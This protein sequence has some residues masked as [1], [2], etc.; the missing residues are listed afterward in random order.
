MGA[1]SYN[2]LKIEDPNISIVWPLLN[3]FLL[4]LL[5]LFD[6]WL[7][8]TNPGWDWICKQS[9]YSTIK[10]YHRLLSTSLWWYAIPH[11]FILTFIYYVRSPSEFSERTSCLHDKG[12]NSTSNRGYHCERNRSV[13]FSLSI[14]FFILS[15]I[16]YLVRCIQT[17]TLMLSSSMVVQLGMASKDRQ[18]MTRDIIGNILSMIM[19]CVL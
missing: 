15:F 1:G 9:A 16:I 14:S 8:T 10:Y 18:A 7:G 12:R 6:V 11:L 4:L 17:V 19:V 13:S 2:Y 3:S 5:I